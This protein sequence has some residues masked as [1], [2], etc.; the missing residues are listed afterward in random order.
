MEGI[1]IF[2]LVA[3]VLGVTYYYIKKEKTPDPNIVATPTPTGEGSDTSEPT[4]N[5]NPK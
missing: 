1:V 2:L 4:S 3:A 5:I